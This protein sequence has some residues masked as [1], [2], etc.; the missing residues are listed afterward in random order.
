MRI[1]KWFAI[2]FSILLVFSYAPLSIVA[3]ETKEDTET[4]DYKSKDE[5]IYGKLDGSG[6]IKDMY[7]VNSFHGL[8][9]GEI[10]DYGKY[11]EVKNLTD[12]S[13]I[14][15]STNE[16]QF[17]TDEKE[18]YYQGELETKTLPWDITITYLLDGKKVSSEELAGQS[19]NL[20][21][22]ITTAANEKVNATFYENYLLQI[23]LTIDPLIFEDIQA[24]EGTEANEGKNKQI[25]FMVLPDQEEEL[26]LTA[27][28]TDLEMDPINISAIPANVALDRPELGNMTGE[29]DELSTAIGDVHAGVSELSDGVSDLNTGVQELS[30]GST[31]FRKGINELDGSSGDLVSG[32][33][34]ILTALQKIDGALDGD[35]IMPDVSELQ[36]LPQGFREMAKGLR[37]SADGIDTLSANYDTAFDSLKKAINGIPDHSVSEGEIAKLYESNA[38]QETIN[39]LLKTYEAAQVVKQ[40]YVAVEAGFAAVSDTL[41]GV[42]AP[43]NNMA[44]QLDLLADE[45]ES[46]LN[47]LE[48]LGDLSELQDGLATLATEYETFHNGLVDYTDGVNELAKNYRDLDTGLQEVSEGTVSLETGIS[49]LHAGTKELHTSTNDLPDE[50]EKKIDELMKEYDGSD[51][52]PISFISAKNENVDVVQFVLRT[53]KI[54]MVEPDEEEVEEEEKKSM[55]DRFTNLFK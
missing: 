38:D 29:F 16:I 34:D 4:S 13:E 21:I 24:P 14:T 55:W 35:S 9:S 46:G 20:E 12:L 25:S 48:Q 53:E 17:Q 7:V 1:K 40:T 19:G 10:V 42:S 47:D 3:A 22:Q 28:V 26:I 54:E 15:Q 23:S 50:I 45:V 30:D 33:S 51:F 18:F 5:V 52:E 2:L 37:E 43:L 31:E 8:S 36:Q 27:N 41:D 39:K 32:S 44:D 11:T 49:E 6:Q